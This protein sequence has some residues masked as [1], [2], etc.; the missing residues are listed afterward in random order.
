MGRE[1][2][3]DVV[4]RNVCVF[5]DGCGTGSEGRTL[6]ETQTGP[7]GRPF[8]THE[9]GG[10]GSSL[11]GGVGSLVDTGCPLS[12][13]RE[14]RVE[15]LPGDTL[16]KEYVEHFRSPSSG[17]GYRRFTFYVE[18][19][20]ERRK[21]SSQRFCFRFVHSGRETETKGALRTRF[22]STRDQTKIL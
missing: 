6:V 22:C 20:S 2:G 3:D 19:D 1:V 12:L 5:P 15:S 18:I 11:S 13:F 7:S 16:C 14:E 10:T 9:Y 8:V 4:G 21:R 17:D